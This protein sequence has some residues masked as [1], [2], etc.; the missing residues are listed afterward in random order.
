ME[1]AKV[2]VNTNIYLP[3]SAQTRH[4]ALAIAKL[5]G[6][7][8]NDVEDS[9]ENNFVKILPTQEP[10]MVDI[11]LSKEIP[12]VDGEVGHHTFLHLETCDNRGK[13]LTPACSTFWIAI[14]KGLVDTFG[15]SILYNDSGEHDY[16]AVDYSRPW[17][18]NTT[19]GWYNQG[20]FNYYAMSQ[21]LNSIKPVTLDITTQG[22]Y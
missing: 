15:G 2:G 16:G 1:K 3:Y 21:R 6:L 10:A 4:I 7:P 12:T 22:C 5:A 8:I 19:E 11:I 9:Y 20:E 13:L 17:R 14:G 18:D